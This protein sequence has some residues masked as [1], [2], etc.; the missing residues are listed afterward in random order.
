MN[1]E[2]PPAPEWP[3]SIAQS[4]SDISKDKI[5]DTKPTLE[6]ISDRRWFLTYASLDLFHTHH[7]S[8]HRA[9]GYGATE[10][11]LH[12]IR[13]TSKYDKPVNV[14]CKIDGSR[15]IIQIYVSLKRRE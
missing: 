7:W 11:C 14:S 9:A 6:D 1:E 2:L 13:E 4:T 5:A 8:R 10:I 15:S 12:C 3:R